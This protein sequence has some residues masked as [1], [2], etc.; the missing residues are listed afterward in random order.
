M[1]GACR[2]L[3]RAGYRVAAVARTRLAAGLWSRHCGERIVL[4]DPR[5][6]AASFVSG[7]EELV[8]AGR[9]AVLI[10]GA[11]AS[12]IAVSEQRH[13]FEPHVALG[14]PQRDTL[15]RCLDKLE[16]LE[17]AA[18][19]G[20]PAPPSVT[21]VDERSALAAACRLGYP[22][23]LKPRRSVLRSGGAM[24]QQG[25]VVAHDE[26]EV[27]RAVPVLGS[28][29]IVQCFEPSCWLFSFTGVVAGGRLLA[30]TAARVRRTWPPDAGA[31]S[32]SETVQ[33][34]S[35]L[36]EGIEAFLRA[37]NWEGIFQVQLLELEDGRF[38]LIDFNPRPYG[39]LGLDV[40]AGANAGAVWCD[41]LLGRNPAP[42]TAR[43]GVRYRWEEGEAQ[44]LLWQL[45]HRQLRRGTRVLR[46][47]R[48]IVHAHFE[49]TDPAPL[50]ARM[51][52]I[53]TRRLTG[54]RAI[55]T[56]VTA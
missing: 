33:P 23:V 17:A 12:L 11:E 2:G 50:V 7:L 26:P 30:T 55:P 47:H 3:E 20:L 25:V 6:E 10:P 28:P 22:V 29:F 21:C 15:T 4:P 40:R 39:S 41:W 32:F 16:L 37:M 35:E 54:P 52:Y 13:R 24:R 34:R 44:H 31:Q 48:D 51:L 53:A 9:Y 43:P 49:L 18:L 1:L 38:S 27:A 5:L 45:R 42:V 36:V 46:P 56:L 14:L 8:R 19:A